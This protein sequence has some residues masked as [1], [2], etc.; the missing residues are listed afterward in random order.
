MFKRKSLILGKGRKMEEK[1][2]LAFVYSE[3]NFDIVRQML[4]KARSRAEFLDA[5]VVTEVKVPG[6]Y[7][8]P[9]FI[10][11]VLKNVDCDAVVTLGSVITGETEHDEIVAQQVSRKI[12]DLSLEMGKPVTLGISGPGMT[13]D[14]ARSRIEE[15]ARRAV[16]SAVKMVKRLRKL[17]TS[18]EDE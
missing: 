7:D 1:I 16:D 14:Q 4:D 10:K 3:F 18:T 12:T 6:A 8:M 11:K 15:Y 13:T 2:R 5:E 17:K 9:L